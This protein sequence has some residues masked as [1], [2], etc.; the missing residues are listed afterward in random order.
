MPD[1]KKCGLTLFARI[2]NIRRGM[3][4]P[5]IVMWVSERSLPPL[6]AEVKRSLRRSIV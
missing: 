3:V 2:Q 1:V 4:M 6:D 5:L